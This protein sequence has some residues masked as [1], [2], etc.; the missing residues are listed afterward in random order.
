MLYHFV[1]FHKLLKEHLIQ[2]EI[3]NELLESFFYILI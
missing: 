2:I 3:N 1:Y